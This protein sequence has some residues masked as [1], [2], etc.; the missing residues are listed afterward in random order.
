MS[1]SPP[2]FFLGSFSAISRFFSLPLTLDHILV[3]VD[4]LAL[5][6]GCTYRGHCGALRPSP[7]FLSLFCLATFYLSY[8]REE[9]SA[10]APERPQKK[11]SLPIMLT[12]HVS[13]NKIL[14]RAEDRETT[15]NHFALYFWLNVYGKV[16]LIILPIYS[17]W[18]KVPT[19]HFF[20]LELRQPHP[21][22]PDIG[23]RNRTEA[24]VTTAYNTLCESFYVFPSDCET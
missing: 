9:F 17:P 11:A 24:K 21:K 7:V 4:S 18:P 20:S 8:D 19:R 23:Q 3:M 22:P 10:I 13:K 2:L 5:L 15:F 1:R 12:F 16:V 14:R 6:N